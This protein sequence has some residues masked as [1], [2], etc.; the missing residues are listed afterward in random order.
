MI[1]SIEHVRN[2]FPSL[3]KLGR[4][5]NGAIPVVHQTM[6]TDCG[7]ACL[8]MVLAYHGRH[9]TLEEVRSSMSVGRDGVTA[10]AIIEAAGLF[11]LHGRGVK[12]EL[13]DL[14][15]VPEASILFIDF[16]HFVVLEKVDQHGVHIVDPAYGRRTLSAHEA[17]GSFTGIVL[18]FEKSLHFKKSDKPQ[19]P[20]VRHLK[21][22]LSGSR[23]FKRIALV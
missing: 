11:G 14:A 20:V 21:L 23:E 2:V 5:L 17:N 4:A 9:A 19:N 6:A 12:I 15:N 16:S 3:E 22:A 10:R 7:A 8:A 18:L 1:G 13:R